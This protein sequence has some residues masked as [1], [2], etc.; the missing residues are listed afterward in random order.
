MKYKKLKFGDPMDKK[1]VV[2]PLIRNSEV[3]RVDDWVNESV[4]NGAESPY[5][6]ENNYLI[7]HMIKLY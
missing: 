5:G 6:R 4:K 2:G 3:E 1:T 7:P